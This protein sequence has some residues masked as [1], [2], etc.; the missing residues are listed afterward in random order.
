MEIEWSP[1]FDHHLN[2]KL[3]IAVDIWLLIEEKIPLVLTEKLEHSEYSF[4]M[5]DGLKW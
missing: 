1:S 3:K 5:I 4:V 2:L